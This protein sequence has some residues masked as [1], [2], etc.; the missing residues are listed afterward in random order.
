MFF[1]IFFANLFGLIPFFPFGA[2]VTGN[3]SITVVLALMTYFFVNLFGNRHYWKDILWPDVPVFLKA[4]PLMPIIELI[5]TI[6]KPFALMVRLFAN[7]LAGHIVIMVLMAL[8]FIIGGMYGAGMGGVMSIVSIF[9]T[10][11]MTALELLVAYIQAYVFTMLS[12]I[13]IGMAQEE[14]KHE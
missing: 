1:F 2:N 3:L 12:S 13:F 4:F 10:I 5:S 6:T 7:I 8:I 11:F 9:M 14:P